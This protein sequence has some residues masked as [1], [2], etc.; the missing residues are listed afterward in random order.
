MGIFGVE[1]G[2]KWGEDCGELKGDGVGDIKYLFFINSS[3]FFTIDFA[4]CIINMI[5]ISISC[6]WT[7]INESSTRHYKVKIYSLR[8]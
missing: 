4:F 3:V 8:K 7:I 6:V 1:G 5:K 2:K